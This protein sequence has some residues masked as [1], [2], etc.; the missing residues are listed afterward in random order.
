VP[1]RISASL[2][3]VARAYVLSVILAG[4]FILGW[5][6][7][8]LG[9]GSWPETLVF[10]LL[11]FLAEAM[12]VRIPRRR[13]TVSV[14]Y[15]VIYAAILLFTLPAAVWLAALASVRVMDLTGKVP[16]RA[17]LFN[18][19]QMAL[20]A[21]AAGLAFAR[22]GGTPG[23]VEVL[24]DLWAL[25]GAAGAYAAVNIFTVVTVMALTRRL[26]FWSVYSKDFRWLIPHYVALTPLGILI[27]V[28]YGE[29]GLTGVLLLFVPLVVARYSLQLY[30]QIRDAY[31]ATIRA[32][33]AAV[34][35]RDPYTA[36]HSGRVA[37]YTAAAARKLNLS[38]DLVERLEYAAWLHDIGKLA[39]PDRI[40]RKKGRLTDDEWHLMRQHPRTGA[41]ILKEIDLL[42]RDV[43]IILHHHERYD[44]QGY[45]DF[46]SGQ[47]IPLGA[48][49]IAIADAF[50]AMTSERPY[51]PRP[52]TREE[53]F[54]ELEAQAGRQFD[55]ALVK[56]FI[57]AVQDLPVAEEEPEVVV[58]FVP[59]RA[60]GGQ[61]AYGQA[62]A[63][64]EVCE[65]AEV[66][67]AAGPEEPPEDAPRPRGTG[68]PGS[69]GG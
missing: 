28:V 35:A 62:A 23:Q 20:S 27:A 64:A 58:P 47:E 60:S 68:G 37:R 51:R 15:A 22:L 53:A 30:V 10:G 21:A 67:E 66:R 45:P 46:L 43:D 52:L 63:A 25:L 17:V 69:Q 54:A 44:G 42:G 11:I 16:I 13:D 4:A 18:R 55:P 2:D 40:L 61:E 12:P 14:S 6:R 34:E 7:P 33:V 32:M 36:G 24:P 9:Q 39:V 38:E 1:G 59:L 31:L 50:E 65:A 3:F 26:S 29:L 49:L 8:E 48:R 5:L 56:V 41:G 19:A 57:E